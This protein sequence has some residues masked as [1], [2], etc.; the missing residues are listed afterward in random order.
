MW[1]LWI[2]L[3]LL[4]FVFFF[5]ALQPNYLPRLIDF[6]RGTT[7]PGPISFPIVGAIGV[8]KARPWKTFTKWGAIYGDIFSVFH[9]V[10]YVVILAD[11]K[12]IRAVLNNPAIDGRPVNWAGRQMNNSLGVG[13][14]DGLWWTEQRRFL[15]NTLRGIMG[16][17]SDNSP[18]GKYYPIAVQELL[19]S[20]A[21]T[22][23]QPFLVR[24][25][26]EKAVITSLSS[27]VHEGQLTGEDP[28]VP[29]LFEAFST[30]FSASHNTNVINTIF[31]WMR[32]VP[33]FRSQFYRLKGAVDY[34]ANCARFAIGE[35]RLHELAEG[36]KPMDIVDTFRREMDKSDHGVTFTEDQLVCL[37]AELLMA[38]SEDV[39]NIMIWVVLF[40]ALYPEE[41]RKVQDL[42]DKVVG[43]REVSVEDRSALGLVDAF[44]HETM[45]F[46]NA[47]PYPLPRRALE[48]TKYLDYKIPKGAT[49]ITN[50][51]SIHFNEKIFD[52]P[53]EFRPQR[54]LDGEGNFVPSPNMLAF[55]TGRRSCPGMEYAKKDLFVLLASMLQRF[56][57]ELPEGEEKPD[58][59]QTN[60]GVNLTPQSFKIRCTHR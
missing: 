29:A 7:P 11:V 34:M 30:F 24:P 32:K 50:I 4:L 9:G 6:F 36:E 41:Q 18:Y 3:L 57:I 35:K 15:V 39:T 42:L 38:G 16:L 31:P 13:F 58:M 19:A 5:V 47:V 12:A 55:G 46:S 28:K 40:T 23:G 51:W 45:R 44:V 14:A 37:T 53:F 54:F 21:N 2:I 33:P 8:D 56:K 25:I 10:E 49:I 60:D 43:E 52:D 27:V 20:F 1:E 59:H 22:N 26:I 17:R 48:E